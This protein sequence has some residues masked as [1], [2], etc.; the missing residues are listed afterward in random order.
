VRV[1]ALLLSALQNGAAG[2]IY[3]CGSAAGS[4]KIVVNPASGG[5]SR[6]CARSTDSGTR[7]GDGSDPEAV[8]RDCVDNDHVHMRRVLCE[9][10]EASWNKSGRI[11]LIGWVTRSRTR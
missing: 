10:R 8:L 4:N 1:I 11:R 9:L 5:D 6:C 7:M 3:P 2:Q